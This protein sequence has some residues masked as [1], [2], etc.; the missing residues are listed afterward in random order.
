MAKEVFVR[1]T[2]NIH[3][4]QI[5][6]AQASSMIAGVFVGIHTDGKLKLADF[7]ASAGPVVARGVLMRGAQMKDPKGNVLDT[8][9]YLDYCGDGAEIEG[10]VNLT[11]GKTYYLSTGGGISV[12]KP[13]ATTNDIDLKVGYAVSG[14]RLRVELGQE[15]IHA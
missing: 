10:Y 12:T 13:A 7:A 15:V 9:G 11:V 6:A 8:W 5:T 2:G 1:N 4:G 14:T 3:S